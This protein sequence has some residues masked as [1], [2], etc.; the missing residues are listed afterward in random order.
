MPIKAQTL[1]IAN[2]VLP[3]LYNAYPGQ[4]LFIITVL[5]YYW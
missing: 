3:Y 4:N 2:Q 5:M 1:K